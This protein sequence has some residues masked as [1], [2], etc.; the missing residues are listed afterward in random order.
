MPKKTE[1]KNTKGTKKTTKASASKKTNTAKKNTTIK[2]VVKEEVVKVPETKVEVKEV[3]VAKKEKK[4]G[5]K[6]CELMNNTPFVISACIIILL[7]AILIFVLCTKRV[8]TTSKGEEVIATLKGKTITADELYL[9]LKDEAGKDQLLSIIDEYIAEKEVTVTEDDEKY[10]QEVVDYYKDYAKYYETDLETFLIN[11]VGL[12]GISTEEEFAEFVLKDY[13]KTLAVQK[14]IGEKADE[15]DLKK[16]YKENYTDKLTVKH[17][18][19]EVDSEA[20]DKDKEDDKAYEKAVKLIQKLNKAEKD[21]LDELFEE[22][23]EENSDDTATYSTG[24][25][26]EEFAKKDV[27]KEFYEAAYEL[28]DGKYTKEPVKTTYGYHIILKVSSTPVEK[29]KEIKD[30]VKK[31]YAEAELAKDS[32]LVTTKWDELRKEYKLSIKDDFIKK[33]YEQAIKEATKT[34]E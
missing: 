27:E 4:K 16:Y 29:Y 5:K 8:P 1:E 11:Y 21:E 9:K 15:E 17:I 13:K 30:E 14:Y 33:A 19:I 25:L 28:K 7:V 6:S 3:K 24:G 18:L 20:E 32:K 31:A 22:L 26:I 2:K 23:V 10:V 12:T 34:E